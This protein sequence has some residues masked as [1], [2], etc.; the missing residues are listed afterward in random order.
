MIP[1]SIATCDTVSGLSPEIT[2]ISTPFAAKYS[3]VSFAESLTG[4]SRNTSPRSLTGASR[5]PPFGTS[6]VFAIA[7]TLYPLLLIL[8]I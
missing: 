4:L 1:A 8:L 6:L 7:R 2:L 3:K 5:L